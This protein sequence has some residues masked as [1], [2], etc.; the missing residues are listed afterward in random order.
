MHQNLV[1]TIDSFVKAI[2]SETDD[3]LAEFPLAF[4]PSTSGDS[5]VPSTTSGTSSAF[6]GPSTSGT[7][8][9]FSDPSISVVFPLLAMLVPL[10]KI[11]KNH[12]I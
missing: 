2:S 6:S 3:S 5:S 4:P 1:F 8:G 12:A 9:A 7:S 10:P 11:Q